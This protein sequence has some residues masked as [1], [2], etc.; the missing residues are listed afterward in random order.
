MNR[1]CPPCSPAERMNSRES[2][3]TRWF[4][5]ELQPH[6]SEL[7]SYLTARYPTLSDVDN[8][9]QESLVRVLRARQSGDIRSSKSLLFAIARNVAIDTLRRQRVVSFEPISEFGE[10][11]GFID[12]VDVPETVSKRQEVALLGQAIETLP[13]GCRRVFT[14]RAA[15]GLSQRQIAERLKISENTVEKQMAKGIR[16]CTDYFARLGLP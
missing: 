5:E 16:R 2:V 14:L 4:A 9:V 6:A 11:S 7:R 12:P 10:S 8:L 13:A 15:Y 3:D 1:T